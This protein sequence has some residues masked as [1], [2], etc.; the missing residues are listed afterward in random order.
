[1]KALEPECYSS[2][3]RRVIRSRVKFTSKQPSDVDRHIRK[4]A[5][6]GIR[7]CKGFGQKPI[8]GRLARMFVAAEKLAAETGVPAEI[9]AGW[10]EI[11]GIGD[12]TVENSAGQK[13]AEAEI[14]VRCLGCHAGVSIVMGRSR[15]ASLKANHP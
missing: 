14:V 11:W 8:H 9:S 5:E 12:F 6:I 1:M 2:T 10:A 7:R 15:W 3:P 4:I 13:I